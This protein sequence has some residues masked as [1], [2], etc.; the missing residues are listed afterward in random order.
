MPWKAVVA[1]EGPKREI[2][3]LVAAVDIVVGVAEVGILVAEIAGMA[4]ALVAV[5]ADSEI[6]A[7]LLVQILALASFRVAA[8]GFVVDYPH[9]HKPAPIVPQMILPEMAAEVVAAVDFAAEMVVA[10]NDTG[11]L[12]VL[13]E[14]VVA[15]ADG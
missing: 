14:T 9:W 3:M 10:E 2:A 15:E 6:A 1:P 4:V 5:D 11:A 7:S 12:V 13:P 8:A